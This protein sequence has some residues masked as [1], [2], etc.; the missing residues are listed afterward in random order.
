VTH[1]PK[2]SNVRRLIGLARNLDQAEVTTG[3]PPAA[4][5]FIVG[6]FLHAR[7]AKLRADD[8]FTNQISGMAEVTVRGL[9]F[10]L[11]GETAEESE[12]HVN[13]AEANLQDLFVLCEKS[14]SS[15]N[16]GEVAT[17]TLSGSVEIFPTL[18]SVF[19]HKI[20]TNGRKPRRPPGH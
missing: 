3:S 4:R 16:R 18:V 14:G 20:R 11:G 15:R 10:N 19:Q 6:Q 9:A 5:K 1:G 7:D 17:L 13:L 2:L 12:L 8:R